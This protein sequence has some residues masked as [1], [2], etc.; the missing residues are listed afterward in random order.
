MVGEGTALSEE[1]SY[2]TGSMFSYT[3]AFNSVSGVVGE[4]VYRIK[5]EGLVV[6]MELIQIKEVRYSTLR[7]FWITLV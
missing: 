3:E 1:H 4:R 2:V 5:C 6:D 7:I